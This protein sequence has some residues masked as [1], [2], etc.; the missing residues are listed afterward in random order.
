MNVV[1]INK[2]RTLTVTLQ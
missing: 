1:N 2:I